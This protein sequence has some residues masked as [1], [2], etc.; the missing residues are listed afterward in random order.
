[1]SLKIVN[2]IGKKGEDV[3]VVYLKKQGYTI[4]ERN[5]RKHYGEIDIIAIDPSAG[6]GQGAS[7]KEQILVFIEVKTRTSSQFGTPF[8]SI[9]YWK[10]KPLLKTAQLYCAIHPKLP[11]A[12]RIDAIA[13]ILDEDLNVVNIEHQKNISGW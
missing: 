7:E 9:T 10:L 2:P 8:E 3:A 1:M 6:S 12:L 5:Y 11:Q 4:L 13:V